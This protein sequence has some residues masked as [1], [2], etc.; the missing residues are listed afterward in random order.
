MLGITGIRVKSGFY[1]AAL[2]LDVC[3]HT[4]AFLWLACA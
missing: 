4:F 2:I 1:M 3:P